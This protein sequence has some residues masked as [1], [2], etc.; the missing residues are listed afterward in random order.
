MSSLRCLIVA[1][2][3]ALAGCVTTERAVG[4]GPAAEVSQGTWRQVDS[5]IAA[6][7]QSA[8]AQA[9]DYA[10]EAMERWMDLVYQR[11]ES[12]YIPW[13]TGYWTRKWLTIK[14]GWYRLNSGEEKDAVVNRLAVYLQ[15]EY[16]D[17][18]LKPVSRQLDPDAVMARATQHYVEVLA[19]QLREIPQRRG[20]P[21]AQFNRRLS[22]IP[23]IDLAPP[24]AHSVSLFQLVHAD[25]VERLPAFQALLGRV[26]KAAGGAVAGSS[27]T[28][29]APVARE[30]SEKL[31]S[32][33]ATSGIASAIGAMAG[34][35]A[36]SMISL[37]VASFGAMANENERPKMAVQLRKNLNQAFDEEW[38]DLMRNRDSGVLAGVLYLS[39]EIE[40]NL[41]GWAAQ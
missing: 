7:S 24:A 11:T 9:E 1:V 4:P 38:L 20:V 37:G 26:R 13:F 17:R 8:A 25:P 40:G 34:R 16:H 6:A 14:V 3:V 23:A 2:L 18:V 22:E 27:D 33:L 15:E 10:R 29:I 19:G 31:E 5:D 30:T 36:G 39:G 12:D 32:E 21:M 41:V 28:G 35:V